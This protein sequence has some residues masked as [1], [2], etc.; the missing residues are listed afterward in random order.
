MPEAKSSKTLATL[1]FKMIRFGIAIAVILLEMAGVVVF[2]GRGAPAPQKSNVPFRPK[3]PAIELVQIQPGSFNM[4]A[5]NGDSS[6]QP[7]HRVTIG[8]S[9]YLGKYEVSQSQWQAVMGNNPS[10]FKD[11]GSCPA[12]KISWSAAQ[13]FIQLLN[14]LKDPYIYRL[15]TEAEWEYACRAGTTGDYSGNL[16]E[17]AWYFENSDSKTHP[18][19]GKRLNPW[20]LADMHGNVWEWCEDWFHDNYSGAPNDGSAWLSGGGKGRIL[21]GGSW[22]SFA[23]NVRAAY[24]LW[25]APEDPDRTTGFRVAATKRPD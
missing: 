1:R 3:N 12:E 6:E 19:G 21:R 8:Y 10:N 9:F 7:V 5:T 18:V 24:R 23:V 20:G 15:P 16:N 13:K 14:Q 22:H 17:V 4:G 25:S 11:C 2:D